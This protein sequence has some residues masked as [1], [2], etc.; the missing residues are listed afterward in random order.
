MKFYDD[1]SI[2]YDSN[3]N[4]NELQYAEEEWNLAVAMIE[5]EYFIALKFSCSTKSNMKAAIEVILREK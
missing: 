4:I 1:D 2:W 3:R 5:M